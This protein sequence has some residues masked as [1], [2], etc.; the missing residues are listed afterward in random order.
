MYFLLYYLAILYIKSLELYNSTLLDIDSVQ[1]RSIII[2]AGQA[3]NRVYRSDDFDV[4][5][6]HDNSPLTKADIAANEIIELSLKKL[7]VD[8]DVLPIISEESSHQSYE[9]RKHFKKY[10]LVDPLDGTK[11]FINRRDEFTVNIA[12]IENSYPVFGMVYAPALDVL[13]G[14]TRD[15]GSYVI[16]DGVR[17]EINV[18]GS[19][20]KLKAVQS[21]SHSSE[22]EEKFYSHFPIESN[23]S[24]GSSLKFCMVAEGKAHLYYRSGPTMEWDTAAG[25]AIVENA[26]GYVFTQGERMRYNKESLKNPSF[27]VSSFESEIFNEY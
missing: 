11:E 8:G 26:G 22:L 27:I 23:L 6:K 13:Y 24:A 9:E 4:S 5:L 1:I 17:R 10:W 25:Q 20:E 21:R 16:R 2:E 14:G 7:F 15:K 18:K 12:L 19:A 3:I